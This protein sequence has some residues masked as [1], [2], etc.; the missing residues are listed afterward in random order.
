MSQ[1]RTPEKPAKRALS[2]V[3][4]GSGAPGFIFPLYLLLAQFNIINTPWALVVSYPS[5]QLPMACWL[6]LG[7]F[8]AIPEELEEVALLDGCT[9]L[10]TFLRIVLPLSWPG[11]VAVALFTFALSWNEL[12]VA[13][14]FL[15]S[16]TNWT[17]P[18]GLSLVSN[19]VFSYGQIFAMSFLMALPVTVCAAIGQRAMI[20]GLTEGAVKG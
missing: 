4:V 11:L 6:L 18:M 20:G 12:M 17:L 15:R 3:S 16:E 1:P 13:S 9:H 14:F 5:I 2:A 10:G 8:R 7:F 19:E